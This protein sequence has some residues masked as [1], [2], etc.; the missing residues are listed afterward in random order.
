MFLSR[1]F[2]KKKKLEDD[3]GR[4]SLEKKEKPKNDTMLLCVDCI[5]HR[6]IKNRHICAHT[7][8]LLS[9]RYDCVTGKVRSPA[10]Q[11]DCQGMRDLNMF[12]GPKAQYF[13]PKNEKDT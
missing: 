11:M 6:R 4:E 5:Y 7:E 1:W 10:S 8:A 2:F 12:C 9:A 3:V 13:E